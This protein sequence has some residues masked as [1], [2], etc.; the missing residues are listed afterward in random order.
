MNMRNKR[1]AYRSMA[2]EGAGAGGAAAGA[3]AGATGGAPAGEAAAVAPA[4][5]LAAAAATAGG[6]A[7]TTP[8]GEYIPE[9][10]RVMGADGKLDLAASSK[11][12]AENYA[13]LEKRM[14]T[15]DVPPKTPEEYAPEG[16]PEG[17]D[18]AEL[19]KDPLYAGFLKGAHAQGLTNKQVSYVLNEYLSRAP[20][21]A[22]GA[23]TLDVEACTTALKET[24]SDPAAFKTNLSA[25]YRV[26]SVVAQKAGIDMAAIEG[27]AIANDPTFLRL[28]AALGPE[29]AEDTA[30]AGAT[31]LA[32][33][34]FDAQLNE[35]KAH[36]AYM[37]GNHPEH[38]ALM[39]RKADLYAK[40]YGTAPAPGVTKV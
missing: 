9:K 6:E 26:T 39:Q 11:K 24:W 7:A 31:Q 20:E 34:D 4:S 33:A 10:F 37:D 23:K 19:S 28:M 22:A 30:V 5:V 17:V 13:A 27:S 21:I 2:D 14:G 35:I 1:H 8:D 18:I 32:A 25:A 29:F 3:D 16:L 38:K 36:P 15:G 40:R 12:V